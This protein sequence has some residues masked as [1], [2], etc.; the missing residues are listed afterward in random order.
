MEVSTSHGDP[1]LYSCGKNEGYC[2]WTARLQAVWYVS[3][4]D[5]VSPVLLFRDGTAR[6]QAAW[7]VSMLDLVSPVLLFCDGTARLQA[8]WCQC[9]TW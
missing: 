4:L 1:G 5:L 7:Y 6:L 9:Q 2:G 8:V 3:V